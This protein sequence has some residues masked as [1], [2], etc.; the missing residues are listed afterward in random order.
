MIAA[1]TPRQ[2]QVL[3]LCALGHNTKGIAQ[4]LNISHKT[5]ELHIVHMLRKF[6]VSDR[7][8]LVLG[9]YHAGLLVRE[10][11]LELSRTPIINGTGKELPPQ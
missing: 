3:K 6:G 7:L 9:C 11:L 1:F 4:A 10:D 2:F 5:V 8:Q